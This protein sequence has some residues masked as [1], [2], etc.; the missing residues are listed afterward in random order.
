MQNQTLKEL[1]V[2]KSFRNQQ[3]AI[4]GL[5]TQRS[6]REAASVA[7]IGTRT[8]YRWMKDPEFD[9]AFRVARSAVFEQAVAVAR[10]AS[11]AAVAAIVRM[12][13]D[14]KASASTRLSAAE[15]ILGMATDAG[16]SK[17]NGVRVMEL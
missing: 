2:A 13:V 10:Q 12:M 14:S 15:F 7:G 9:L 17:G 4:V 1:R 6:V 11:R 3:H 5:L 8:L 16:E